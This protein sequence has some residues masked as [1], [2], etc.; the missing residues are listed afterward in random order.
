MCLTI[1][2]TTHM[3][4]YLSRIFPCFQLASVSRSRILRSAESL[5]RSV[6]RTYV[7]DRNFSWQQ[8]HRELILFAALAADF[9]V[10]GGIFVFPVGKGFKKQDSSIRCE[11]GSKLLENGCR[12]RNV[13][14]TWTGHCR[15][16]HRDLILFAALAGDFGVEG[17][18]FDVF[19]PK[20][21]RH[22]VFAWGRY[23]TQTVT[24]LLSW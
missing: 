15:K 19:V 8:T 3:L 13:F 4:A 14:L 17:V 20:T 2:L 9:G 11:L 18:I 7:C 1:F 24:S 22:F 21:E 6:Y 5:D 16:T 10:E 12:R 23:E